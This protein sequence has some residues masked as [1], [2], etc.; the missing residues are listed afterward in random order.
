MGWWQWWDGSQ[1]GW[2]GGGEGKGTIYCPSL[3]IVD[4]IDLLRRNRG[5]YLCL[6]VI[7][8]GVLVQGRVELNANK[9][10]LYG[11]RMLI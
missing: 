2:E 11:N 8:V 7:I 10:R 3:G 4:G 9:T 6:L 1:G 5:C